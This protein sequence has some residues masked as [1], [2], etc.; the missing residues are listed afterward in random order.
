M[1][2]RSIPFQRLAAVA[3][4]VRAAAQR[5]MAPIRREVSAQ[6]IRRHARHAAVRS[7]W[8][9]HRA[10]DLI[11]HLARPTRRATPRHAEHPHHRL[12]RRRVRRWALAGGLSMVGGACMLA[13]VLILLARSAPTWWRQVRRDDPDTI[14][15]GTQVE[16]AVWNRVYKNR[17]VEPEAE[18]GLTR[19]SNP[20]TIAV[21][22]KEANAWLNVRLPKWLTNQKDDFHWPKDVSDIQVDFQPSRVTIGAKVRSGSRDQVLTATLE[23]RLDGT[24]RLY[25]PARWVN[26]GRLSIPADWVLDR[27]TAD[28]YIPRDLKKLP[29]TDALL[30]AFAGADAVRNSTLINLGDGRAVRIL[31]IAPG[32]GVLRITCRTE[33]E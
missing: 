13:L 17:A 26:L 2:P 23:P 28:Q 8:L 24:G 25:I 27:G 16:N 33:L 32:D 19:V 10:N 21:T 30:Q 18:A 14:A 7:R 11:T 29:E 5:G 15:L 22:P 20:W 12:S 9:V 4:R 1:P 6:R 31:S 3:R